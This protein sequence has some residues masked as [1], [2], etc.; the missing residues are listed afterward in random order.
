MSGC[1]RDK[2]G[3][4]Y[5]EE[6]VDQRES[7]KLSNPDVAAVYRLSMLL[8]QNSRNDKTINEVSAVLDSLGIRVTGTG[9]AT[10]S[11]RI[12]EEALKS[13]FNL[14]DLEEWNKNPNA[15]A[16]ATVD[17]SI[18]NSLQRYIDLISLEPVPEYYS[19]E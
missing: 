9:T 18:P 4:T 19:D 16:S 1:E 7:T 5:Q 8:N 11:A 13:I 10:I 2:L 17:L 12:G 3:S 6:H 15:E 14:Q